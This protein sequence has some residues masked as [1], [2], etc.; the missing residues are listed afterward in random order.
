MNLCCHLLMP[1]GDALQAAL[2]FHNTRTPDYALDTPRVSAAIHNR[3]PAPQMTWFLSDASYRAYVVRTCPLAQLNS[4]TL[5]NYTVLLLCMARLNLFQKYKNH[6]ETR[7][8]I[9]W[10][11]YFLLKPHSF[12][13]HDYTNINHAKCQAFAVIIAKS[14]LFGGCTTLSLSY[15]LGILKSAHSIC[16]L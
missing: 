10:V 3:N 13:C 8:R 11:A 15:I 12:D 16:Q 7:I 6:S 1:P 9:L 5:D 4:D 14:N 2:R